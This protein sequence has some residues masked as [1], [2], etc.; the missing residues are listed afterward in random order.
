[1]PS[2]LSKPSPASSKPAYRAAFG[3]FHSKHA[4]LKMFYL[5]KVG[6]NLLAAHQIN[7]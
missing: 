5:W 7:S 6:A 1:M 2:I 3:Q 4:G